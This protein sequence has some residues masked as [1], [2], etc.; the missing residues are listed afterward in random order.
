[1]SNQ[2]AADDLFNL[3]SEDARLTTFPIH[4][5]DLWDFYKKAQRSFWTVDEIDMS[6]DAT[7]YKNMSLGERNCVRY[8]LGFFATGDAIVNV[9]LAE[10]FKKEVKILEASYFYDM[11]MNIE[12][13]HAETYSMQLQTIIAEQAE[14]DELFSAIHTIPAIGDI[15]AWMN[16]CINSSEPFASRLLKMA[17]V[18]GVFFSGCFCLIYWFA[19]RKLM[20]GLAQANTLI[21]RD[22]GLHTDFALHLYKIIRS[23]HKLTTDQIHAI[24]R[25]AFKIAKNFVKNMLPERVPGMNS[26]LMKKY[27]KFVINGILH[28]LDVMLL[29]KIT[30]N[31]MKFME[32]LGLGERW[33]FFEH[34]PTAYSKPMSRPDTTDTQEYTDEF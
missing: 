9:N 7:D 16:D 20:P 27:L 13:I 19:S 34:R 25:N 26:G 31:P 2:T 3:D 17:C 24:F 15:A 5:H 10:R 32:L 29:Y 18:E 1:M 22:E 23:S 8:I 14:R 11:Q 4:R 30:E 21:A 33:N 6:R 28:D 12:N